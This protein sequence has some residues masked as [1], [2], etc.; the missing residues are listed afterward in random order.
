MR[1]DVPLYLDAG[2]TFEP[3]IHQWYA[4]P[5][6]I[7]PVTSALVVANK[8]LPIMKSFV[9]FPKA[10]RQGARTPSLVGGAFVDHEETR[11]PDIRALA[12]QI[13]R[14]HPDL[15]ALSAA[16]RQLDARLLQE[17]GGSLE[18]LYREIPEPLRGR[19]ELKYDLQHR[20][21]AR[22][23]EPLWYRSGF[24]KASAQSI[25]LSR[26]PEERAFAQSTPRLAGDDRLILHRPFRHHGVRSLLQM[27]QKP[28]SLQEISSQLEISSSEAADLSRYL[29]DRPPR[30]APPYDGDGVRVRYFGHACVLIE[31]R[32]VSVLTDPAISYEYGAGPERFSY[33]DLPDR[34]D[35]V[36]LTHAHPDH[37]W[38]EVLLQIRHKLGT[39]IVPRNNGG[40]VADPSL[41]LALQS[42]GLEKVI[43]LDELE[44]LEIHGGRILALPF[45]G[46][47]GDLDIRSKSSYRIQID[48]RTIVALGDTN[49]VSPELYAHFADLVGPVDMLWIGMEALGAPLSWGYGALFSAPPPREA[50]QARRLN[51]ASDEAAALLV[52]LF[53]P[54]RVGIYAMGRERWTA[55]LMGVHYTSESPQLQGISR[56]IDQCRQRQIPV[57]APVYQLEL[58]W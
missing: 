7:A 25:S 32:G 38:L 29:T 51:S 54:R 50:D 28:L 27:R 14:D 34:I 49:V 4:V 9:Q 20:A 48:G 58:A 47:H 52:D 26:C 41:R 33:A 30:R 45:L 22:L 12:E 2:V 31:A 13:E 42:V 53:R 3:L 37:V 17:R 18:P 21:S 39:V 19:V 43:E 1:D 15:L 57:D 44:E 35:Y 56:F 36:L 8:Y 55:H 24:F 6:L 5:Y 10:H 46:E 40:G 11:V 16:I 23:L